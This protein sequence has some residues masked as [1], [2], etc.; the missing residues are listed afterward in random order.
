MPTSTSRLSYSDCFEYFDQ[1]LADPLG[2]AIGF[3]FSGDARQFRLRMNAARALDREENALV[4]ASNPDHP[5]FGRSQYDEFQLKLRQAL[6][7]TYI[8]IER[9]SVRVI[10]VIPL[11]EIEEE[12]RPVEQIVEWKKPVEVLK[13]TDRR[14]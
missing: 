9:N 7:K 3:E 13:L 12:L 4:Y 14:V 10:E 6:G 1:A 5:L 2:L 11:S 8:V